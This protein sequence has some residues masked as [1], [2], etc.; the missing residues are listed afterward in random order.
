MSINEHISELV[1]CHFV[2]GGEVYTHRELIYW[3]IAHRGLS[4]R[5]AENCLNL[6][7]KEGFIMFASYDSARGESLYIR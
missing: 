7:V 1:S 5:Q 3:L 2:N 4:A 6:A